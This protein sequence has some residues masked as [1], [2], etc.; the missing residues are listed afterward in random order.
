VKYAYRISALAN[1]IFSFFKVSFVSIFHEKDF[2]HSSIPCDWSILPFNRIS[3]VIFYFKKFSRPVAYL[4]IGCF[5]D[6]LFKCLPL[7][8]KIGV[9]PI[10][11]GTFRNTSDFFFK[12]NTSNFDLVFIDGLHHYDQ[13]WRD[14]TNSLSCLSEDGFILIHDVLP[15]S[16]A[17]QKIPRLAS[18]WTGDCWKVLFDIYD[19][20][21]LDLSIVSVDHGV[22]VVSF[23]SSDKNVS[24]SMSYKDVSFDFF[25]SNIMS[26][27]I[28][29]PYR[30]FD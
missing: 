6:E 13:V 27:D 18:E 3:V 20:P 4:E 12:N 23:S 1:K 9:D 15:R 28:V 5:N 16:F 25:L 24:L 14:I 19:N 8:K 7:G 26:I 10:S 29:D 17:E 11:G 2:N 22:A 30:L 21:L